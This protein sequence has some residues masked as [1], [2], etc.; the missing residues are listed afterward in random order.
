MYSSM[1]YCTDVFVQFKAAGKVVVMA[2]VVD[3]NIH[4]L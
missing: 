1:I 2:F 3:I 4:L